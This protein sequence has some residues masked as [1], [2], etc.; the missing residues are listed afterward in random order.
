MSKVYFDRTD[1]ERDFDFTPLQPI[2]KQINELGIPIT[3]EDIIEIAENDYLGELKT[4][5]KEFYL[6]YTLLKKRR[7]G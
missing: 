2:V 7:E 1:D 6:T 3:I 4:K 5:P